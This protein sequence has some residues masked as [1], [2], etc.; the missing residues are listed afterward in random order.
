LQAFS[1]TVWSICNATEKQ[2]G[3][4]LFVRLNSVSVLGKLS[5]RLMVREGMRFH[6]CQK[7]VWIIYS[8]HRPPTL[9]QT[10]TGFP[11]CPEGRHDGLKT[12]TKHNGRILQRKQPSCIP[13][14]Q[15]S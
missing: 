1:V 6:S 3:L 11:A 8:F 4:Q 5:S 15:Q 2:E 12:H 9:S 7:A 10:G 14:L 13:S